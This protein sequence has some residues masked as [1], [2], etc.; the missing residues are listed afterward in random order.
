MGGP[1]EAAASYSTSCQTPADGNVGRAQLQMG[2][3]PS[4]EADLHSKACGLL[5]PG[6]ADKVNNKQ[7]KLIN[8]VR[9]GDDKCHKVRCHMGGR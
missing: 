6:R 8:D 5:G 4:C 3:G 2:G 1:V 9:S 7:T